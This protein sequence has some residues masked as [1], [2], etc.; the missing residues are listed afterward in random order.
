ME[1]IGMAKQTACMTTAAG[2]RSDVCP[3]LI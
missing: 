2:S 1:G 3:A